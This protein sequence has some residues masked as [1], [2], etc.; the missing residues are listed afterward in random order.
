VGKAIVGRDKILKRSHNHMKKRD[1]VVA[2]KNMSD[3]EFKGEM[4]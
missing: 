1:K 4:A 2:M 3:E